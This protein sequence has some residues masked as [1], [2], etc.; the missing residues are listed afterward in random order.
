MTEV[1]AR[2]RDGDRVAIILPARR[3]AEGYEYGFMRSTFLL[4]GRTTIPVLGPDDRAYPKNVLGANVIA[5]FGVDVDAP[6]FTKVWGSRDGVLL[7]RTS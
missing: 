6:H 1:R 3:W 4:Y 7:R 5:A 2:T